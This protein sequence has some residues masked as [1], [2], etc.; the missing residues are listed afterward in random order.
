M[1]LVKINGRSRYFAAPQVT[2]TKSESGAGRYDV[3]VWHSY[4][5]DVDL[6][7]PSY[8]FRVVGGRASGG[9]SNEW[10][11]YRPT[12]FGFN[13]VPVKSLVAAIDLGICN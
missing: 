12:M 13:Y 3:K 5:A 2:V 9:A 1:A 10:F 11:V 4:L 7:E 8:E 6:D